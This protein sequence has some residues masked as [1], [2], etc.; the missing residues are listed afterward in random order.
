VLLG[1]AEA[2][3]LPSF[4]ENAVDDAKVILRSDNMET[5]TSLFAETC[6]Y[7]GHDSGVTHLAAMYGVPVIA[8]FKG[9]S[10]YQWRPLGPHVRIIEN[11]KNDGELIVKTLEAIRRLLC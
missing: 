11:E 3:L 7:V 9:S 5:L 4:K 10:M 1:P 6:L 8:L 2:P